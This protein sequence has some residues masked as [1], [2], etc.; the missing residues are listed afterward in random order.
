[1]RISNLP[2]RDETEVPKG[3]EEKWENTEYIRSR[4]PLRR[5]AKWESQKASSSSTIII[6]YMKIL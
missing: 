4:E 2:L 1:M 3:A 6:K 5:R